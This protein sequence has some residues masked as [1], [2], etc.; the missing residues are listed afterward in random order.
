[1]VA[2]F[3]RVEFNCKAPTQGAASELVIVSL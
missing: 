3:T 1:M 2:S